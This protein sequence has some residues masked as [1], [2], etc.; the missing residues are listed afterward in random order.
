MNSSRRRSTRL[1]AALLPILAIPLLAACYP[2][3]P[4]STFDAVGPVAK[5]Q[6]NLFY[7][8]FWAAVFVFVVVGGILMWITLR[9]RRKPGDPDPA[10]T[11]GNTP[12]EIGWT[13]APALVLVVIAVPTVLTIFDNLN[14][15]D[16]DALTIDV[17]GHQ[18]WFEFRYPHPDGNGDAVV[19]ANELH[20]PVGEVVNVNLDSKDV[21]HS[22]WIPKLAGKVDLV[23]GN[24]NFMWIQAD[25]PGEYLGQCA[26]FCGEAHALMK[27]R[28]VAESRSEF[29]AWLTAEAAPAQDP[30]DPLAQQGKAL[31]EGGKAQCWSCH[32]VAGSSKSRGQTGPDLTHVWNRGHIAAGVIENNQRNLRQWIE[33]PQS[34]KQGTIMF[35]DAK[36]YSDPERKLT[37][38][39]VAALVAYLQTLK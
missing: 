8:I 9:F 16:P 22:F 35:R 37:D 15:P 38:A 1:W 14:S 7:W 31:F 39:D 10:Q 24:E 2:D 32:T 21:L 26:E 18:W 13:I 19:T 5:S 25:E 12:L 11:H 34:I 6:L 20:I 33:D 27:F 17:V 36:I 28:V 30:V 23:P 4:Q 3:N 29:D